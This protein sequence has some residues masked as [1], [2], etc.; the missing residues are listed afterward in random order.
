MLLASF[1]CLPILADAS[2]LEKASRRSKKSENS[3]KNKTER[4]KKNRNSRNAFAED[5]AVEERGIS[6]IADAIENMGDQIAEAG[7]DGKDEDNA[8]EL[9][10]KSISTIGKIIKM[11]ANLCS[12]TDDVQQTAK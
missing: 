9:G 2:S 5:E 12:K 11:L 8:V 6:D 4:T 7:K 1:V 10:G 3:Y